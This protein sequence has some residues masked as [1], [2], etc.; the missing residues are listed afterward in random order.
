MLRIDEGAADPP[1][2][3]TTASTI[4]T[5]DREFADGSDVVDPCAWPTGACQAATAC[6]CAAEGA[7]VH[8]D[9][10][11]AQPLKLAREHLDVLAGDGVDPL[12]ELVDGEQRHAGQHR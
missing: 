5:H 11:G 4:Y 7:F 3:A 10:G 1:R 6:K 2:Y 12:L 9:A 8:A